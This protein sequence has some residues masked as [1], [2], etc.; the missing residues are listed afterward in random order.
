MVRPE[1]LVLP[2]PCLSRTERGL[3]TVLLAVPVLFGGLVLLRSA[4]LQTRHTDVGVY[5]R[6][7]WAVRTGADLYDVTDDNGWHY[8]YPPLY[9]ILMAP[10]ADPPQGADA[11]GYLPYPLSV[12]I[13]YVFNVAC[14]FLAVELL[15]R[16]LERSS[17]LPASG[18]RRWLL[19]LLPVL[20]CLP[21]IGHTLMR[22]Q[23]NL[24]LLALVGGMV[25]ATLR[26]RR[27][28]AGLCLAGAIC[29][30][31][32]PAFLLLYPLWQRDRRGLA[33]CALGL[34]VGLLLIPAI[35]LGPQ[36][37]LASYRKQAEVLLGPALALNDHP[38]RA[39]ELI[40]V[41][42]SDSQSIQSVLTK[43]LY[44]DPLQ[45]PAHPPAWVRNVHWLLG[46]LLTLATLTAARRRPTDA[47]PGAVLLIGALAEVMLLVSPVCHTHYFC[48]S[49]LV[50]M[51]LL[52]GSWERAGQASLPRWLP[53]L[54]GGVLVGNVLPLLP[55][56]EILK[57]TGLAAYANLTLWL[58]G[59][60]TLRRLPAPGQEE[61]KSA[62]FRSAA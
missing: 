2:D 57:D 29:L 30:K 61:R 13:C 17:G 40:E 43:T 37:T 5:L 24:L 10:L 47:G 23:V 6:A 33:G 18:R 16:A 11:N 42:A 54:L 26:G 38:S 28:L 44:P 51:G 62:G 50:V 34:F 52:A 59:C 20:A 60:G 15:A 58:A 49:I 35:V 3:I 53:W 19:R 36:R 45:R 12:A 48:L 1:G 14:L 27:L 7:G 21:P 41:N 9:A 39:H 55:S 22:G 32:I 31:I 8:H 56:L 4:F 25:A 46:G